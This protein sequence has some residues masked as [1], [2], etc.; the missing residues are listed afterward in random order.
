MEL[1]GYVFYRDLTFPTPYSSLGCAVLL[2]TTRLSA[3][4]QYLT[5]KALRYF[6]KPASPLTLFASFSSLLYQDRLIVEATKL[7]RRE[8]VKKKRGD[9]ASMERRHVYEASEMTNETN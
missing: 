5:S 2:C 7:E 4:F 3:T 6:L 8:I 1:R 9:D